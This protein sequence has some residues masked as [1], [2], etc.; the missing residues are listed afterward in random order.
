M[1]KS[2]TDRRYDYHLNR[3]IHVL[4]DQARAHGHRLQGLD[5]LTPKDIIEKHKRAHTLPVNPSHARGAKRFDPCDCAIAHAAQGL[6]EVYSV[7]I[8]RRFAYMLEKDDKG[9]V[10]VYRYNSPKE[11]RL[12]TLKF[13]KGQATARTVIHFTPVSEGRSLEYQRRYARK[14]ARGATGTRSS[15]PNFTK[16]SF[17]RRYSMPEAL[18]R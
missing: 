6:P 5:R 4:V 1:L 8:M 16:W 3:V 18:P 15:R 2:D 14:W 12:L 13:D 17:T 10:K 9:H 11:A 7:V